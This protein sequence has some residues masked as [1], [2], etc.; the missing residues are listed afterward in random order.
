MPGALSDADAAIN[1]RKTTHPTEYSAQDTDLTRVG[2]E[3][4]LVKNWK[5]L[6]EY[7]DRDENSLSYFGYGTPTPANMRV[8]TIS[9]RVV[10][11]IATTNGNAVVT[12]GYDKSESAYTVVDWFT[13]IEQ[14]VDGYYGQ[15]VYPI[16]QKATVTTGVR[17]SSVDD[18][19]NTSHTN[20]SDSLNAAEIGLN[21]QIDSA[22]RVFSRYADGF[23]FA[24]ADE[25]GFTLPSVSFLNAQTSKSYEAGVAWEAKAA[26]VKYSIY[27]MKIDDE[28]M[29]DSAIPNSN[30]FNGYGANIN[31]PNSERQGFMFDGDVQLSEQFTL[32]GNYTYTD[33]SLSAG[34]FDGNKVPFVAKDA[35]NIG[36]VFNFV[37]NVSATFDA[38][39]VGARYR[40]GDDANTAS[41][42]DA[43]TLFNFNILWD[44]KDIELGFRIKNIT[45]EKYSDYQGLYGQYPQPGRTYNARISYRF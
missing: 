10:G 9:P 25:N 8:K 43:V 5:L 38:N 37:K 11:S 30:S 15:V 44:I 7:S 42:V 14:V 12:V 1:P 4:E 16:T 40:I 36:V 35:A 31:L 39:Y 23:R 22:W 26:S 34:A 27:Q 21:Y 20:N 19:N 28:I 45:A 3:I 13:D 32:R 29:Y 17:H 2:G 18:T 24:N 6:G 33:A 41:I